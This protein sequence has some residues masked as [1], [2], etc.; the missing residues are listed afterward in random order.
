MKRYMLVRHK[1]HYVPEVI[2]KIYNEFELNARYSNTKILNEFGVNTLKVDEEVCF[3]L[4]LLHR[5]DH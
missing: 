4:W 3:W 5:I 1:E 2:N